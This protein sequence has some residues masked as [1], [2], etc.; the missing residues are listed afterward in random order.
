MALSPGDFTFIAEVVRSDAAIVLEP[1]KEYLVESRLAPVLKSFN[2][3]SMEELVA[4][5][6]ASG[7]WPGRKKVVEALTTNETSFFRD[8]HP[9]ETMRKCIIPQLIEKRS[10][11]KRLRIW[12]AACSTGQEPYS[13]AIMLRENF[14][15]I[16]DWHVEIV[17]TDINAEVLKKARSGSYNQA[18]INRGLPAALMIRYFAKD[19]V[20]W[21]L[22]EDIRKMVSFQ[23]FNLISRSWSMSLADIILIRNVLIYFDVETKKAILGRI[24]EVMKPD[25]YL[26]LGAAETTLG[27][28]DSFQRQSFDKGCYYVLKPDAEGK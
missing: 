25:G 4:M 22:K 12:S 27:L 2:I 21:T 8:L 6:K 3:P 19:G 11:L 15:Q 28:N 1:G 9:F 23:E 18:E 24:K 26:L 13:I 14:P 7:Q 17:A 16:K 10:F 20:L 5:L